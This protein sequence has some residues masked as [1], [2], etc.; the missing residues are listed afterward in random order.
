M[1]G[2][3]FP[4]AGPLGLGSPPS[5]LSTFSLRYYA[6]LR[7]PL[8]HLGLLRL[9]LASRYLVLVRLRLCPLA[10]S[11]PG[12]DDDPDRAWPDS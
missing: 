8:L 7:R 12:C 11:L 9:K 1:P 4:T 2:F 6:Q 10:G 3:A 5:R